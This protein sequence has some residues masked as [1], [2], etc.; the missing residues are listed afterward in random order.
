MIGKAVLGQSRISK[1]Y[2]WVG[3]NG[4]ATEASSYSRD[5]RESSINFLVILCT[6]FVAT[7]AAA[8]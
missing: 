6:E 2:K 4:I 3:H 5:S 8:S 7:A 1:W